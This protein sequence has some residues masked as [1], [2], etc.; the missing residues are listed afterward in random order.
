MSGPLGVESNAFC[1]RGF[2]FELFIVVIISQVFILIEK[3]LR[4]DLFFYLCEHV[5]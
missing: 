4:E 3:T 1:S 5:W 2:G